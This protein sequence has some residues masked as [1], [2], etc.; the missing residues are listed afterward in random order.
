MLARRWATQVV[1]LPLAAMMLAGCSSDDD[2]GGSA[3]ES[4]GGGA[5]TVDVTLQEFAIATDPTSA[6]AGTVTFDI[7]NEGPDDAHEFVVF[8]TDLGPTEL[9]TN[10]DGS[11]DEEGEGVELIDEQEEVEPDTSASL[12]VDLEAGSY[13]FIC[14][15]VEKE[16]G[17]TISHYQQGMRTSFTVQ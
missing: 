5:S 2:G 14:N 10:P 15:I 4:A 16:D 3:T 1:L 17:E 11:V 6:S 12:D 7:S 8:R 13:V 9:P